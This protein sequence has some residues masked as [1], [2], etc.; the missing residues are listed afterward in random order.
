MLPF[1]PRE[2]MVQ[3]VGFTERSEEP[4]NAGKVMILK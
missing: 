3:Q 1:Y 2:I 4:P